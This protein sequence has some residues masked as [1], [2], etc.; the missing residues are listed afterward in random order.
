MVQINQHLVRFNRV[1]TEEINKKVLKAII[2]YV[3]GYYSVCKPYFTERK[4]TIN[5]VKIVLKLTKK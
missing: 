4:H 3:K 5:Q 1:L 2:M